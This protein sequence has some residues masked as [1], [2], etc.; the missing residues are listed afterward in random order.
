MALGSGVWKPAAL[1]GGP[2]GLTIFDGEP[3][4]LL[5]QTG[6]RQGIGDCVALDLTTLAP[7]SC[8]GHHSHCLLLQE[9]SQRDPSGI[10]FGSKG[11]QVPSPALHHHFK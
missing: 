6:T 5:L 10:S 1:T 2:L 7:L 11:L 9:R 4:Q 8:Q 3:A